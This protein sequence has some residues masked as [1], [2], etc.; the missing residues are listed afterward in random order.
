MCPYDEA[1]LPPLR[2]A[3]IES[4]YLPGGGSNVA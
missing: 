4:G 1:D 3:L 2:Q